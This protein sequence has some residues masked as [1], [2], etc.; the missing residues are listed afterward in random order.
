MAAITAGTTPPPSE[1]RPDLPAELEAIT[2][3]ALA[4]DPADRYQTADELRSALERFA[5]AARLQARG[6]AVEIDPQRA[7]S[8]SNVACDDLM[9]ELEFH[10]ALNLPRIEHR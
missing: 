6:V 1:L 10:R 2:L 4:F 5:V 9:R 3:R 8:K 7:R